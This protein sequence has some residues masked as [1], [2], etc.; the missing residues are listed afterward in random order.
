M[1]RHASV[2]PDPTAFTSL[3]R[4][5]AALHGASRPDGGSPAGHAGTCGRDKQQL[6]EL[7]GSRPE[8]HKRLR[9]RIKGQYVQPTIQRST[10]GALH[11]TEPAHSN[12][13]SL[14]DQQ[15]P[16]SSS[17]VHV[18]VLA[19]SGRSVEPAEHVLRAERAAPACG[20]GKAEEMVE[21]GVDAIDCPQCCGKFS[22]ALQQPQAVHEQ[23]QPEPEPDSQPETASQLQQ[24]DLGQTASAAP[25]SASM[26]PQQASSLNRQA[27]DTSDMNTYY[28]PL[29][30]D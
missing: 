30:D 28:G 21:D 20:V 19:A 15:G 10:D 26:Q 5:P 1:T 24:D 22:S 6:G 18:D 27:L 17:G 14:A 11:S 13:H 9:L 29:H 16:A 4:S 12:T 8:Q 25:T 3:Q 23:A 2:E 7:Q